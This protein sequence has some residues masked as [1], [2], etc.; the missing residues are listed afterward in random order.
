M[1]VQIK[2]DPTI[3]CRQCGVTDDKQ[4]KCDGCENMFD[5]DYL[6]HYDGAGVFCQDCDEW[7]EVEEDEDEDEDDDL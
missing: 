5:H 3:F 6:V 2:G 1:S 7:I 4:A